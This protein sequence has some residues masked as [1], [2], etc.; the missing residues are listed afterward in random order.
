MI[1]QRFNAQQ[2]VQ[3]YWQKKPCLI[4]Q[5]APDFVD[6]IDENDLAGLAQEEGV[7]S[8]IV[9]KHNGVWDVNQGP[10][11]DFTPFCKGDWALLVQGVNH[12]IDEVD[13]LSQ[14]VDFIPYWRF[15]DVMVSYSTK[16]AGVGAHTDQYDVFIIQGKGKRRWQVGLPHPSAEF[17]YIVSPHPLL[18]LIEDFT[19]VIDEVLEPGDA[20]YIPPKHPHKGVTMSPCLNYSLGF[21]AP[22]N[23]ETLSGMLDENDAIESSQI[24]YTDEDINQ[25]RG[26]NDDPKLVS[27]HEL[28]KLQNAIK[29]L[30]DSPQAQQN[31]LL[32]LS[33]QG[34]PKQDDLP[35]YTPQQIVEC[36]EQGVIFERLPG[37]KPIYTEQ[38]STTFVFFIDGTMFEV[39]SSITQQAIALLSLKQIRG[40]PADLSPTSPSALH[41]FALL[42]ELV[43]AGYWDIDADM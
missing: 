7:D 10:F 37:V 12:Y 38:A 43:N 5:F 22:T 13:E 31:L 4:K 3:D 18:K 8:R 24:R 36:I 21:R 2:F 39:D 20:I 17:E 41:W 19:P 30:L 11:E 35:A 32:Y 25:L 33:R 34:L 15:D 40:L 42:T 6:P 9:S 1:I 27:T 29:N 26:D 23:F 14:L 16:N 28:N